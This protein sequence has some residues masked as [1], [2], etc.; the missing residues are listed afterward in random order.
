MFSLVT[1]SYNKSQHK[2]CVCGGGL[3]RQ[4]DKEISNYS[5]Y[6]WHKDRRKKGRGSREGE[7]EG[8][9]LPHLGFLDK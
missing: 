9:R 8:D 6:V 2:L 4:P 7:K 5:Q 3:K 1:S